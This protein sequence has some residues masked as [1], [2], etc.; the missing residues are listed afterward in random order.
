MYILGSPYAQSQIKNKTHTVGVPKLALERIKKIKIPICTINIQ[1]NIVENIKL[2]F[3]TI[4]NNQ[5][6]LE[7]NQSIIKNKIS[8]IWSN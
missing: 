2:D 5:R 1:K 8:S 4:E 3:K 7:K 6:L